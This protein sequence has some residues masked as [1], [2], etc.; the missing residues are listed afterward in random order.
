MRSVNPA[1]GRVLREYPDHSPNDVRFAIAKAHETFLEWRFAG[2]SSRAQVLSRAAALLGERQDEYARLMTLEMGRPISEARSEIEKCAWLCEYYA[3]QAPFYMAPEVIESDG[4]K[5]FVRRDP[6]GIVLAVM[7]WNFPFWQVFRC[8]AP[9]L[10]AGNTVLLKHAP[11]VSGCSLACE[12]VFRAAGIPEGGFQSLLCEVD[13]VAEVIADERVAG[14]A[15]TGSERA[16]SDVAQEAGRWVKRS[17]LELGGSDPFIVLDDAD[18]E[19]AI[20]G[21]MISRFLNTGQSCIAAKRFIVTPK[22]RNAF[23]DGLSA[24]MARLVVGDPLE[25]ETQI[26]PMARDDLRSEL[27][28]QV[29][30]SVAAGAHCVM[31]GRKREGEGFFYAPTLL[32]SVPE[33]APARTEE[34]FGPLA[35]VIE[36]RDRDHAV[37]L[38]NDSVYGLGASVWSTS[39]SAVQ[40][41]ERLEVGHVAFNGIVK[42]D[43]RLP[44]GGIKRSGYGRELSVHGLLEFVN[45]KTVWV[46]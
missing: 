25:P 3:E 45:L 8:A 9:A 46:A 6:L 5:S 17:V 12:D 32:V 34:T 20:E 15:L 11:N 38:A 1:T 33:D 31:G 27:H 24:S 40:L 16:G 4:S 14:V 26:G 18:V 42:S 28:R 30:E 36:A 44:F 23:L 37:E 19:K 29:T 21:A 2:V 35:V 41:A 7:P 10:A 43:P 13:A 22:V 39:K